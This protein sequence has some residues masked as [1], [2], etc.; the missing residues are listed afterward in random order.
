MIKDK[1]C[2]IAIM[3]NALCFCRYSYTC[4]IYF[5]KNQQQLIKSGLIMFLAARQRFNWNQMNCPHETRSLH[6]NLLHR[7]QTRCIFTMFFF[8]PKRYNFATQLT[9]GNA[10]Q[11][12][13]VHR[14][15]FLWKWCK[16]RSNC[17]AVNFTPLLIPF[18]K[19]MNGFRGIS[20]TAINNIAEVRCFFKNVSERSELHL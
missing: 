4:G 10:V 16:W 13:A 20:S 14:I 6:R 1:T 5:L 8:K 19:K 12:T 15:F 17:T 9:A 2:F 7:S 11:I 18:L 3:S